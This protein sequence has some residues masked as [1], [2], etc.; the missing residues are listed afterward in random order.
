MSD[1]FEDNIIKVIRHLRK[2]LYIKVTDTTIDEIV[3]H[4]DYPN[5]VSVADTL[6]SCNIKTLAV[7]LQ[8]QQLSQIPLPAVFHLRNKIGQFFSVVTAVDGNF[9]FA[10]DADTIPQKIGLESFANMWSGACLLI[11]ATGE[12]SELNFDKKRKSERRKIVARILSYIIPVILCATFVVHVQEVLPRMELIATFL[13]LPAIY[14]CW[15]LIK[16]HYGQE[17]EFI[18]A[19]CSILSKRG[20]NDVLKSRASKLFGIPLA[21]LGFI[22]FTSLLVSSVI[23]TAF[24]LSEYVYVDLTTFLL[25]ASL[26]IV[27]ALLY[28]GVVLKAWCVLCLGIISVASIQ[29]ALVLMSDTGTYNLD[30]FVLILPYVFSALALSTW[31]WLVLRPGVISSAELPTT[32]KDLNS[33]KKNPRL[34]EAL[35]KM[36]E[37]VVDLKTAHQLTHGGANAKYSI[38]MVTNPTCSPCRIAHQSINSLMQKYPENLRVTYRFLCSSHSTDAANTVARNILT[39][40]MEKGPAFGHSLL[41]TWYDGSNREIAEQLHQSG[42]AEDHEL[43]ANQLLDETVQWCSVNGITSTP[44][45]I[46]N[47]HMLRSPLS[48]ENLEVILRT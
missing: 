16:A 36:G 2:I 43:L 12:A 23:L 24:N 21:E 4:P 18:K 35:V 6:A 42:S 3:E 19:T 1:K 26:Y 48:I 31:I 45:F 20:C 5:M 13:S 41:T 22:Y 33:L 27:L 17:S 46:V 7:K 14:I 38:I 37:P 8:P 39:M 10:T 15:Q 29:I 11:Q 44:S 40:S 47:G 32:K 30:S 25:P 34:I 9:I 28:Q